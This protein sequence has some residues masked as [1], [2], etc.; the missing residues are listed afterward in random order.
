MPAFGRLTARP[1]RGDFLRVEVQRQAHQPAFALP[2]AGQGVDLGHRGATPPPLVRRAA[3]AVT[4]PLSL[5]STAIAGDGLR[6]RCPRSST[7]HLRGSAPG[8]RSRPMRTSAARSGRG[9]P[10][11]MLALEG[12]ADHHRAEGNS[13]NAHSASGGEEGSH[14]RYRGLGHLQTSILRTSCCRV[15]GGLARPRGHP[16]LRYAEADLAISSSFYVLS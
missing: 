8:L 2:D 9:G 14:H 7:S 3:P 11:R 5:P 13:A 6:S 1:Q 12:S 15:M 4:S 10:R 16:M